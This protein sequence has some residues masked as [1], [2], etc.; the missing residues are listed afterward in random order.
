MEQEDIS[1]PILKNKK[2]TKLKI[3]TSECA[4][5]ILSK[6]YL[7]HTYMHRIFLFVLFFKQ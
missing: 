7:L 5:D 1:S 2:L 4:A 3:D 6:T